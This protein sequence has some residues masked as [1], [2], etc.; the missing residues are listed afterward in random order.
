[1]K[2]TV[3]LSLYPL[4]ENYTEVIIDFIKALK[5]IDAID[6]HT[7]S[8]STYVTGDYDAVM[9]SLQMELKKIYQIV[10]DSSTVI[11]IIPKDLNV[12]NGFLTF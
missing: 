7:T 2:V 11:K 1:M 9:Q 4:C 12:E 6:V 8:M 5:E 10:P 3:E